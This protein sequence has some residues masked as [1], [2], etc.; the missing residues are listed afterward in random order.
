VDF[1]RYVRG[2]AG[3]SGNGIHPRNLYRIEA[4]GLRSHDSFEAIR[5]IG[6][7]SYTEGRWLLIDLHGIDNGSLPEEALGWEPIPLERLRKMLDYLRR[8]GFWIAPFGEVL[9]YQKERT[10]AALSYRYLSSDTLYLCLEDG[11]RD[12]I[13]DHPLTVQLRV[14]RD[15]ERVRVYKDDLLLE[16]TA[17][18]DGYL[19]CYLRPDGRLIRVVHIDM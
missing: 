13:Y 1:E 7:R 16:E 5:R 10:H 17:T 18:F 4:I 15:W 19:T 11:L 2:G 12:R 6:E 3:N 8:R 9:R 14:P